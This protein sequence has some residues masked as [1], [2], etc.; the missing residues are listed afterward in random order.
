MVI[1][2]P[3]PQRIALL[4]DFGAASLYVGQVRLLLAQ[5]AP[6]VAIIDL[7]SDL[8][9]MQPELAAYL[10]PRLL[11]GLPK[12]TLYLCVVDPGVGGSRAAVVLHTQDHWL[13]GPNNGLLGRLAQETAPTRCLQV[14]WRPTH[15]SPT[16]HGRDLFAPLA[17]ALIGG[18][19]P[20]PIHP[21]R[22]EDII[23]I[24]WPA[25]RAEIVYIDHYG[26]LMT[27]LLAAQHDVH[28]SLII[29]DQTLAFAPTFCAVPHGQA[30]WFHNAL[31]L[32]EIAVNGGSA[33]AR[34]QATLGHPIAWLPPQ[35]VNS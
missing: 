27:G 8:P 24:D 2:P 16:F 13:I 35:R 22:R 1:A 32:V 5:T 17:A 31:G 23:G 7:I 33:A 10:L 11:Q 29:A 19:L 28:D 20:E 12:H 4:T 3:L 9:A 14:D 30:F 26:N 21:I 18:E 25:E 34:F 6:G 15:C